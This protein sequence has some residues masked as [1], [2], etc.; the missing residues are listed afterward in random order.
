[1][2]YKKTRIFYKQE[3]LILV[4]DAG[5]FLGLNAFSSVVD[6]LESGSCVLLLLMLPTCL[7]GVWLQ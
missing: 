4:F 1:M 6:W 2:T 7:V 3:F 5:N